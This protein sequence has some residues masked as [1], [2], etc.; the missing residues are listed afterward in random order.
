VEMIDEKN[1]IEE[2]STKKKTTKS[3]GGAGGIIDHSTRVNPMIATLAAVVG[4]VVGRLA[5]P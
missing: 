3:A 1:S 5:K 4:L 2:K